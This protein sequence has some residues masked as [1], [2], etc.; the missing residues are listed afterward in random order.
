M[1]KIRT[2]GTRVYYYD[3]TLEIDDKELKDDEA[4]ELAAEHYYKNS[5]PVIKTDRFNIDSIE[6][7]YE[8]EEE[9]YE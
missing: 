7:Q 8:D 4:F 2:T 6:V 5:P 3:F 9:T 1:I